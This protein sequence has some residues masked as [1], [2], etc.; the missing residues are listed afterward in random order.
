MATR[1]LL[2][3]SVSL[4]HLLLYLP[5]IMVVCLFKGEVLPVGVV[6]VVGVVVYCEFII[7]PVALF[8]LSPRLRGELG[9]C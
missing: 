6:L 9:G 2:S 3:Y 7:Q 4:G 1:L 8:F 5:S